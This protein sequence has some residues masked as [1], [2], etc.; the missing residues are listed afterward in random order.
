MGITHPTTNWP[1]CCLTSLIKRELVSQHGQGRR[2][3][4]RI[5]SGSI[6]ADWFSWVCFIMRLEIYWHHTLLWRKPWLQHLL[7][8]DLGKENRHN[9]QHS[10]KNW[11]PALRPWPCWDTSSR[12]IIEV[13]QH[14]GQLVVG[15]V[16]PIQVQLAAVAELCVVKL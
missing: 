14:W 11:M 10:D 15:W 16:T 5:Y 6:Q 9:T 1:Q 4:L 3:I 12:L 7:G 8:I 13:K 2:N